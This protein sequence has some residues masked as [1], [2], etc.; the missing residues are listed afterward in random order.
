MQ[1]F[2]VTQWLSNVHLHCWF[3]DSERQ[4]YF[5]QRRKK[6]MFFVPLK[7]LICSQWLQ[8][9]EEVNMFTFYSIYLWTESSAAVRCRVVLCPLQNFPDVCSVPGRCPL[10]SHPAWLGNELCCL[11]VSPSGLCLP[12]GAGWASPASAVGNGMGNI[13]LRKQKK[14]KPKG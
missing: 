2:L 4:K 8:M 9:N 12:V 7:L 1:W 5:Y 6:V 11:P 14:K 13:M 10:C 3:A